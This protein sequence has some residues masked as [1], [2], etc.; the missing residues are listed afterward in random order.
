MHLDLKAFKNIQ[1]V[2][3]ISKPV[4]HFDI[5]LKSVDDYSAIKHPLGTGAIK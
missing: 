4:N 5:P 2:A 1:K 3:R